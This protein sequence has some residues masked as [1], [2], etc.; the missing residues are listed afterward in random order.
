MQKNKRKP[1]TKK[2]ATRSKYKSKLRARNTQRSRARNTQR[3]RARKSRCVVRKS[4]SRKSRYV[5]RKSKSRRRYRKR[6]EPSEIDNE[7][8]FKID[9]QLIFKDEDN[10]SYNIVIKNKQG[11]VSIDSVDKETAFMIIREGLRNRTI[12]KGTSNDI[13]MIKESQK[14]I[15]DEKIARLVEEEKRKEAAEAA[16]EIQK[17]EKQLKKAQYRED[18]ND[19][20]KW[21]KI[22]LDSEQFFY[23][24]DI[25]EVRDDPPDKIK[26][27]VYNDMIFSES[28]LERAGYDVDKIKNM[29]K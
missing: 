9:K 8:V 20:Y 25:E 16:E 13:N 17:L 28:D 26:H 29:I 24:S 6:S 2:R 18:E 12:K 21:I 5:V 19:P 1:T 27:D 23:N 22:E 15:Q 11:L 10:D 14:K 3:S 4:P 7:C